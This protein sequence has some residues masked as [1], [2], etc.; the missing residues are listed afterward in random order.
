MNSNLGVVANEFDSIDLAVFLYLYFDPIWNNFSDR[1][2]EM[3]KKD[4][5]CFLEKVTF[6]AKIGLILLLSIRLND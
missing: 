4:F 1:V 5:P 2:F 3:K 6:G